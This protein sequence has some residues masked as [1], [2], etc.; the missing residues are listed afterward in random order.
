MAVMT[1]KKHSESVNMNPPF[2]QYLLFSLSV[3]RIIMKIINSSKSRVVFL[4][5][6]LKK[7]L[8]SFPFRLKNDKITPSIIPSILQKVNLL[9]SIVNF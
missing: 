7:L 5:L 6:L 2:R 1:V 9:E 4:V 3:K 8:S